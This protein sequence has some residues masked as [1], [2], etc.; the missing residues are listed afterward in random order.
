MSQP[1]IRNFLTASSQSDR[2]T[3]AFSTRVLKAT[4]RG[5]T[6]HI[7][8]LSVHTSRTDNPSLFLVLID[9]EGVGINA[10]L[11]NLEACLVGN[12]IAI[13]KGGG[14]QIRVAGHDMETWQDEDR[15][16]GECL[17]AGELVVVGG[18]GGVVGNLPKK[19]S[20]REKTIGKPDKY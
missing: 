17:L 4:V 14:T 12:S 8:V 10:P 11:Y 5:K 2:D 7:G 20:A 19:S 9:N 6:T 18:S 3:S 16:K 15:F 13:A 1:S